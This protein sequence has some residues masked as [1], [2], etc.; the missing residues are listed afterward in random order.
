MFCDQVKVSVLITSYNQKDMVEC[1]IKSVLEQEVH[2]PIEIL[3]GDDGSSDGTWEIVL[4]WAKSHPLII[5]AF[6]WSRDDGVTGSIARV[7]RSRLRLVRESRGD[8]LVFLDGDDYFSQK[9]KLQ[10]Q[11]DFLEKDFS[12]G[13]CAHNFEYV[14][15]CGER[16]ST[17]FFEADRYNRIP[18]NLYWADC[19]LPASS[20]MLRYPS[21]SVLAR[22]NHNNFDDNSIVFLLVDDR[23]ILY[24]SSVM[25]SYVQQK[26]STW[27]TMSLIEKI[28][29]SLQDYYQEIAQYPER[30]YVSKIRHSF[31]MLCLVTFTRRQLL[32]KQS[33][34]DNL[35]LMRNDC[36]VKEWRLLTDGN[37]F[38][39]LFGRLRIIISVMIPAIKKVLSRCRIHY[40]LNGKDGNRIG[41]KWKLH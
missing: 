7:S 28:F 32:E 37:L 2:F 13:A 24:S 29:V 19:Y 10:V 18:F 23:D 20:F 34:I 16:I 1:A 36:F 4:R 35:G 26:N 27:N 17:A 9:K 39:R 5:K 6:R 38:F 14:T 22:V 11:F 40:L 12:L 31:E 30:K 21:E 33:Y 15:E 8:Y 41:G 3:I 25:F